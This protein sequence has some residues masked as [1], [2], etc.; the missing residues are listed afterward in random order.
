MVT[1][2]TYFAIVDDLSS[3]EEPVGGLRRIE[4]DGGAHDERFGHDLEWTRSRPRCS[5]ERDD[6]DSDLYQIS[7]DEASRI[8]ERIRRTVT[9][10]RAS[11]TGWLLGCLR[12]PGRRSGPPT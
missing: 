9:R 3:R 4:H 10:H 5:G 2:I 1:R 7:V 8:V 11:G 12:S 6:A